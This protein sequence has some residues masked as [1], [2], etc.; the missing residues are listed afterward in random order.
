V[1]YQLYRLLL[2][3]PSGWNEW[4]D[5]LLDKA[6]ANLQ[7]YRAGVTAAA[8]LTLITLLASNLTAR[9]SRRKWWVMPF[10]ATLVLHLLLGAW[11]V[12][13]SPTPKIDVFVF[14]QEGARALLA[15][16]NPYAAD[17]PDIYAGTKQADDR[18]VYGQG[19]STGG[20]LAFGFPYPPLSLG[21]STLGYVVAKDHR[22]AQAVA[23]TLAGALVAFARPGRWGAL[24][25]LLLLFTPRAFF[26]LG[27]GWTEPF[28]VC[29]LALTVAC[30][31]RL[32][33]LLPVAL[34]LFL[35]SKQYLVFAAPLAWLLVPNPADARATLK[36]IGGALLVAAAVSLPL[37]LWDWPAF[38]RSTVTVQQVSPFREDALSWLVWYFHKT[39]TKLDHLVAFAV[40]VPALGLALW[41]CPRTPSGFALGLAAVYLPFIAFNKQAFANYY[42]FVIGTL[43][44]AIGTLRPESATPLQTT[45]PTT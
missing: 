3:P 32:P 16:R 33:R 25:A 1:V 17:Y 38:W 20:K 28:V 8:A 30:A 31:Y 44:C 22:Y 5:D 39:G 13:S 6:P 11:L 41:R 35:A 34:G 19:L 24:A 12:R 4:S 23:L 43:V 42:L 7:L 21:L 27:R 9:S 40:A 14:Q 26:V 29:L 10:A 36:L 15:G 18:A 2:D 37:A 45:S